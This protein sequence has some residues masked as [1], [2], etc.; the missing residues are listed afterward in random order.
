MYR[1]EAPGRRL[2]NI[3]TKARRERLVHHLTMPF[4]IMKPGQIRSDDMTFKEF[5]I[6]KKASPSKNKDK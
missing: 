2:E 6:E 1:V 3:N 5:I 4:N